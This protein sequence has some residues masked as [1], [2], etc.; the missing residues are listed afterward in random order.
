MISLD[1]I[2]A[3]DGGYKKRESNVSLK[4]VQNEMQTGKVQFRQIFLLQNALK[5]NINDLK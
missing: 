5:S 4:T 1:E 3:L 2:I